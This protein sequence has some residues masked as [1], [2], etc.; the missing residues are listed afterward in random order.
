M[1]VWELLSFIKTSGVPNIKAFIQWS[2]SVVCFLFI[3]MQ[4][5]FINILKLIGNS[6]YDIYVVTASLQVK[7]ANIL[8]RQK[9]GQLLWFEFL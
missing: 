1:T 9:V 7:N 5:N 4:D 6:H 8:S 2:V 3:S